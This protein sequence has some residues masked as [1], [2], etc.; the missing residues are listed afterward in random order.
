MLL[1][2]EINDFAL[3]DHLQLTFGPGLTILSGETGAG[4]S[5]LIDAV[6]MCLGSRADRELVKSG[7]EKARVQAVFEMVEKPL[8]KALLEE[9]GVPLDDT[10]QLIISREIHNTGRSIARINGT[11]VTQQ[12][13]KSIMQQV[14]DLHGQHEHQSLLQQETHLQLLDAFGGHSLQQVKKKFEESYAQVLSLQT[15]LKKLGSSETERARQLDFLTYQLQE[16]ENAQLQPGEEET[17]SEQNELLRHAQQITKVLGTFHEEVYE[18]SMSTAVLDI[19][20]QNVKALLDVAPYSRD[21]EAFASQ[22][23]ELQIRLQDFSRELNRY[24]EHIEFDPEEIVQLQERLDLIHDLKRKYGSTVEEVLDFVQQLEQEKQDLVNSEARYHK[25]QG[26]LDGAVA[27]TLQLAEELHHLRVKAAALMETE[28]VTVLKELHMGKVIF[29]V[30]NKDADERLA[31]GVFDEKGVDIVSFLISTNPGEPVKPL[32][33]IASGGEMSRI[34]LAFKTIFA[35]LDAIPTLIFD[36]IDTGI[37]GKTAQV[38]GE[39]MKYVA[40]HHQVIC[41]THL[42]QIAALADTHLQIQKSTK[43]DKTLVEVKQLSEEERLHELGRLL[44]GDIS[45]I[46]LTHAREM[47]EKAQRV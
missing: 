28:M 41:I 12:L 43:A 37:S 19:L 23:E 15:E 14:T 35:R 3:I 34:M 39:K 10:G 22:A 45:E 5:I 46:S 31:K 27:Q 9:A 26:E 16:I 30:E 40:K 33:K 2:L 38:V 4:K 1:E 13:L 44:D 32:S 24:Q 42:P 18:G 36:E 20:G 21:L 8:Y 11:T 29:A 47:R 6:S 25:I 7:R 17:L